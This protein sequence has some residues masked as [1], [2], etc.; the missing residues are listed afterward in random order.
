[1]A[2]TSE[3]WYDL[4]KSSVLLSAVSRWRSDP[5]LW[6]SKSFDRLPET[7]RVNPLRSDMI[8]VESW[9]EKIGAK[10]II[11]FNDLGGAWTLPFERGKAEGEVKFIL[12]SLHDTGR[13]TR[14]EAVSMIPVIALDVKPG[15]KVLDMCASPGSKT[16]QIS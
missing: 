1:M 2:S 13:I 5:E 14:Q 11:W 3:Y 8:W 7:V 10:R 16:T 15:Q 12:T 6:F 9:L 4:G